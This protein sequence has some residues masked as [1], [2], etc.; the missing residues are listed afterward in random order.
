MAP[1]PDVVITKGPDG[2]SIIIYVSNKVIDENSWALTRDQIDHETGKALSNAY[3][4][5]RA[6]LEAKNHAEGR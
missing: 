5:R 6:F 4:E 1:R 3:K 2:T